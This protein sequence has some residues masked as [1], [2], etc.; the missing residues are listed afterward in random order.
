M[1]STQ[2]AVQVLD[3][4][5]ANPPLISAQPKSAWRNLAEIVVMIVLLVVLLNAMTVSAD[6]VGV[7]MSPTLNQ[8]QNLL[9]S[10]VTYTLFPPERGDV[11]VLRDPV[12][13][14]RLIVRRVIGLPGERLELR[15]RQVLING[16]PLT[17]DYVDNP[18]AISD[19]LTA[20]ALLVLPPDQYYVMGDNRL[21]INDSRSWGPVNAETILG[22]A[23]FA[24]WPPESIGF[25]KHA[26]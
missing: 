9:A 7:T 20:T 2:Q 18:L 11:I 22:R 10:R 24:Y 6:L 26:R 8:G 15:G 16:L 5:A 25:I 19:N 12:S 23:W 3:E 1:D 13:P 4:D 14:Q 17:E 21:S